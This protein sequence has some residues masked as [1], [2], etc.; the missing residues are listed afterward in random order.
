M[1]RADDFGA[2]NTKNNLMSSHETR[3]KKC[4][5]YM[6]QDPHQIK[7]VSSGHFWLPEHQPHWNAMTHLINVEEFEKNYFLY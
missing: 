4:K 2:E 7:H 5:S 1:N 3:A 6:R